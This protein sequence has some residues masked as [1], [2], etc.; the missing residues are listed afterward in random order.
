MK[1][2]HDLK[3]RTKKLALRVIRLF[4]GLPKSSEAQVLGKQLLRSGT[5]VGVTIVKQAATVHNSFLLSFFL[6]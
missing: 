6:L 5:S 4:G 3:E 2:D 1:D